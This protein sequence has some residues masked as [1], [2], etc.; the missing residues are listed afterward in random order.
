MLFKQKRALCFIIGGAI[1]FAICRNARAAPPVKKPSCEKSDE[2]KVVDFSIP[3]TK[4]IATNGKSGLDDFGVTTIFR[5]Y[6]LPHET[7][8]CKT[9][10]TDEADAILLKGFSIGVVFQHNSDD[11]ATFVADSDTA[12]VHAQRALDLAAANG[13]PPRSAIYFGV[14]GADLHL[15]DLVQEGRRR[16]GKPVSDQEIQEIKKLRKA[17]EPLTLARRYNAFLKYRDEAF[18]ANARITAESLWGLYTCL[19]QMMKGCIV[20]DKG[21]EKLHLRS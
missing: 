11:P 3:V 17:K 21:R 14:D 19:T 2:F 13:Q 10:L 20:W 4:L 9:Q 5:Y 16:G 1:S 18:G 15:N 6:D 12:K 8:P 7:L